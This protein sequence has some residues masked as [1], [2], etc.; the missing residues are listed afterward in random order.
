MHKKKASL[1]KKKRY[2]DRD[3]DSNGNGNSNDN[4]DKAITRTIMISIGGVAF[5]NM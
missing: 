1:P 5:F 3:G 4:N 2:G